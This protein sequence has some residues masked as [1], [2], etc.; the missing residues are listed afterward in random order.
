MTIDTDKIVDVA[1]TIYS[2]CS[3][4][5]QTDCGACLYRQVLEACGMEVPEHPIADPF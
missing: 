5:E 4:C 2:H 1:Q 3:R